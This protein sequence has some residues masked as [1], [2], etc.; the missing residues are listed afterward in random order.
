MVECRGVHS[1]EHRKREKK[2]FLRS[3]GEA[4]DPSKGKNSETAPGGP[5]GETFGVPSGKS[6]GKQ[7]LFKTTLGG[8]CSVKKRKPG[9]GRQVTISLTCDYVGDT[10]HCNTGENHEMEGGQEGNLNGETEVSIS[11]EWLRSAVPKE[12]GAYT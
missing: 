7:S 8:V 2:N 3:P 1:S 5:H 4:E 11:W 10:I 12:G 6:K 9:L